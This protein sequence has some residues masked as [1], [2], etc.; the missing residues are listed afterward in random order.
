M[1]VFVCLTTAKEIETMGKKGKKVR[2][3]SRGRKEKHDNGNIIFLIIFEQ[4]RKKISQ[5]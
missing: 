3:R 5:C 2:R 4:L 1:F